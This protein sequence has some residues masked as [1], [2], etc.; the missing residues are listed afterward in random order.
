M[1]ES[2]GRLAAA[3]DAHGGHQVAAGV[4]DLLLWF[5]GVPVAGGMVVLDSLMQFR[6]CS[7]QWKD[8]HQGAAGTCDLLL[9]YFDVPSASTSGSTFKVSCL[10][11]R[12]GALHVEQRALGMLQQLMCM[13]GRKQHQSSVICFCLRSPG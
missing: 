2:R 3:A 9:W 7:R 11:V 8:W 4:C 12:R 13:A 5:F 1:V 6:C 10:M